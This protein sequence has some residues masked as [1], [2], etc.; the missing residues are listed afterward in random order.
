MAAHM[1][2]LCLSGDVNAVLRHLGC[3]ASTS[4]KLV[5][6]RDSE[7]RTALHWS[8]SM[9]AFD[10]ALTLM[11]EPH[12]ASVDTVD[13]H[14]S[15]PL[16]TAVSVNA[17]SQVIEALLARCSTNL[18]Q[19]DE[20]GNTAFLLACS[21]GASATMRRLVALGADIKCRNNRLQTGLHRTVAKGSLE[22]SEEFLFMTKKMD[23][24]VA[25]KLLN[26]QDIEGNTALHYASMDN[27][28]EL[29]QMLIRSG[30]ERETTN[31]ENKKFWEL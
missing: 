11:S 13:C 1:S 5:D 15:T 17:P 6:T 28:Q 26:A 31:K 16:M 2:E 22:A 20:A 8:L 29:G 14:G 24:L 27:N 25:R 3:I 21:R 19:A 12:N 10:M 9:K 18:D 30:V 23:K 7:G 4:E